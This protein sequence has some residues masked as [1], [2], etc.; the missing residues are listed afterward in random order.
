MQNNTNSV[1]DSS[2]YLAIFFMIMDRHVFGHTKFAITDTNLFY[3][4]HPYN[5]NGRR[6]GLTISNQGG[7]GYS[8]YVENLEVC[9]YYYHCGTLM[10]LYVMMQMVAIF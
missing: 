2:E 5:G 10:Q 4:N 1:S 9:A 6:I 8:A 3:N 7:K